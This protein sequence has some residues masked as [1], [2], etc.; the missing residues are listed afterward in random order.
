MK[1]KLFYKMKKL[2]TIGVVSALALSLVAC[3]TKSDK[4]DGDDSKKTEE[5]VKEEEMPEE[6]KKIVGRWAVLDNAGSQILDF[7]SDGTG[8]TNVYSTDK[9]DDYEG[10]Y[11]EWEYDA[12]TQ[13]YVVYVAQYVEYKNFTEYDDNDIRVWEKEFTIEDFTTPTEDDNVSYAVGE[14][15]Q[16]NLGRYGSPSLRCV[17]IEDCITDPFPLAPADSSAK[18][19]PDFEDGKEYKVPAELGADSIATYKADPSA[20]LDNLNPA[21]E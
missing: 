16:I 6:T 2:A 19:V 9:T 20:Y 3:G 21:T 4:E 13:K 5:I 15:V 14:G 11:L 8:W 12:N 18:T 1:K 17:R 7:Y 10:A